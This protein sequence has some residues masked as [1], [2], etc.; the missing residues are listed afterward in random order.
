[1]TTTERKALA[2]QSVTECPPHQLRR[3][4]RY[5]AA[6]A[7]SPQECAQLLDMLG[8]S[9]EDGRHPEDLHGR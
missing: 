4:A 9:A 5:V 7:D 8:L 2:R 3:A 6:S 1:M